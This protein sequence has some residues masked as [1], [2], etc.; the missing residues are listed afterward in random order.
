MRDSAGIGKRAFS[1]V[2][3]KLLYSIQF[4]IQ[5]RIHRYHVQIGYIVYSSL[6]GLYSYIH[7][8]IYRDFFRGLLATQIFPSQRISS[9]HFRSSS[10]YAQ[11]ICSRDD[12]QL[13]WTVTSTTYVHDRLV[14][15]RTD[16][17]NS[18]HSGEDVRD[19]L[20]YVAL[21]GGC[22]AREIFIVRR[23]DRVGHSPED[24][25]VGNIHIV[26]AETVGDDSTVAERDRTCS[27]LYPSI[28]GENFVYAS[29]TWKRVWGRSDG[30]SHCGQVFGR[31]SF[32]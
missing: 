25:A 13:P 1:T 4:R 11:H 6:Y 21:G 26:H 17:F 14:G 24:A 22:G 19:D 29:A 9:R 20:P 32:G 3:Y 27:P 18:L 28:E 16:L 7:I 5:F 30:V 10:D 12:H 8:H 23:Q 2:Q 31:V 15:F